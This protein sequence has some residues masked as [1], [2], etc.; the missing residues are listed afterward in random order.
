MLYEH[1]QGLSQ[2]GFEHAAEPGCVTINPQRA[3]IHDSLS[4]RPSGQHNYRR[5]VVS[6]SEA[7]Q[8]YLTC[9]CP[10]PSSRSRSVRTCFGV[11][12]FCVLLPHV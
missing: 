6:I 11:N 3:Y 7:Q 10:R 8:S 5:G 12:P 1:E 2:N 4:F 9:A